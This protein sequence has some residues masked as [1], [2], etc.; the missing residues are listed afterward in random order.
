MMLLTR[1]PHRPNETTA[2]LPA[3]ILNFGGSYSG[4]ILILR[5][6][7]LTSIGDL[8]ESLSQA[9]L[10]GIILVGRF[11]VVGPG[12]KGSGGQS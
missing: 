1:W 10:V 6:A 12:V 9:I 8:P 2:N 5:G 7:I 4:R 11:G 3:K